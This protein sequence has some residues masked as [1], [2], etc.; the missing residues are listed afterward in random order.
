MFGIFEAAIGTAL[1][2]T[3]DLFGASL[4]G[5][6]VSSTVNILFALWTLSIMTTLYGFII[7]GRSLE[8]D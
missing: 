6:I 4:I 7:E 2:Q 1:A 5:T 3:S 8:G